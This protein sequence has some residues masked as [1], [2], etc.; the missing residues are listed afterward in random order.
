MTIKP[1]WAEEF[2]RDWIESWNTH[3]LARVLSHYSDD[4]E[5]SS[6]FIAQMGGEPSGT[7]AGKERVAAY[8]QVGL[9]KLPDLHFEL[10]EV[11]VGASSLAIQYRT[12]FGRDAVEVFFFNADGLVIRAAA[13][14]RDSPR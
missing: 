13:H 11:L 7:L 5:M 2:A 9:Q 10:L 8:W 3:D 4:F 14:Y 1:G 6:P 12:N